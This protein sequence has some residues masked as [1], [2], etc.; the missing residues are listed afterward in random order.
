MATQLLAAGAAFIVNLL[1][2][3]AMTPDGRGYLA[4]FLQFGYLLSV[5]MLLG[6]ER[7]FVSKFKTDFSTSVSGLVRMLRPGNWML[8]ICL[9]A[10]A[11]L[12]MKNYYELAVCCLLLAVF[13]LSNVHVR[14]IRSAYISSSAWKPFVRNSISMHV[15]ILL[16][17]VA[18][19]Y[20]DVD[21]IY[22][23]LGAY[24]LSS[25]FA[26]FLVMRSYSSD[27]AKKLMEFPVYDV[28]RKQGIKLLPASLGN[29]AMLK[30]DRLLIPFFSAPA[31][32]GLYVVV[33]TSM[34]MASWPIQQWVDSKL[35]EWNSNLRHSVR[36]SMKLILGAG[37][38]AIFL[39]GA[40]AL[41]VSYIITA[42]LPGSYLPSLQL[43]IPLGIA[44]VIYSMTRVQHGLMIALGWPGRVSIIEG[45][46]MAI[47]LLLYIILIPVFGAFGASLGLAI[48]HAMNLIVGASIY[49]P[50][51]RKVE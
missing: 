18:L 44:A 30:S 41:I 23:W 20:A 25:A 45:V 37:M 48:G 4:L 5:V 32:L 31:E 21:E 40:L 12:T 1:A 27:K 36:R 47:S 6:I 51:I 42:W 13:T 34:D 11:W 14:I 16:S 15:V 17:S 33:A 9:I 24:V 39:S 19:V 35:N 28:V 3:S 8:L 22:F 46:G 49:F 7:P 29:S 38:I 50:Y 26:T 2:A 10:A 43:I